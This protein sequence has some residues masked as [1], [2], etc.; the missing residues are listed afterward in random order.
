MIIS[1]IS[2]IV[3]AI[4]KTLFNQLEKTAGD[5]FR[6]Q[7]YE[8][9]LIYDKSYSTILVLLFDFWLSNLIKIEWQLFCD[10]LV[11]DE[12]EWVKIS[13][14]SILTIVFI[15]LQRLKCLW[16]W[17]R[18]GSTWIHI[19]C[20]FMSSLTKIYNFW[21]KSFSQN[22]VLWLQIVMR[23]SLIDNVLKALC[24]LTYHIYSVLKAKCLALFLEKFI[25]GAILIKFHQ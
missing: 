8:I 7:T 18:Y 24:N 10:Y 21:N 4:C 17:V 22:Y 5:D 13:S 14:P 23:H 12:A 11:H 6:S 20:F 1:F 19:W 16:C 9:I 15:I 3:F 2:F 25:Q